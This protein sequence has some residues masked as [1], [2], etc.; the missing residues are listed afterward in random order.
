MCR[1]C[2]SRLEPCGQGEVCTSKSP[3]SH[4]L[5]LELCNLPS[6]IIL[7]IADNLNYYELSALRSVSRHLRNIVELSQFRTAL[8]LLEP[9]LPCPSDHSVLRFRYP[10]YNC[11]QLLNSKQFSLAMK[12]GDRSFCARFAYSRR[13]MTCSHANKSVFVDSNRT[14]HFYF[15]EG[16]WKTCERCRTTKRC[17]FGFLSEDEMCHKRPVCDDC[18]KEQQGCLLEVQVLADHEAVSIRTSQ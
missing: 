14:E 13:C 12:T 16:C 5:N 10:C 17:W 9:P 6:E 18:Y 1:L 4:K 8:Q 7:L 2:N 3:T 11:L 15:E